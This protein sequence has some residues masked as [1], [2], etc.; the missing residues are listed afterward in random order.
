MKLLEKA[1]VILL[2]FVQIN[3]IYFKQ[4]NEEM[5]TTIFISIYTRS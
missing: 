2:S 1:Y 4:I 5:N 3:D